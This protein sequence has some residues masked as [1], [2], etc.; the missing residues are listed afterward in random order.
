MIYQTA[1]YQ[2]N[3][4][5]ID[6]VKKAIKEFTLYVKKNEP[7]TILYLAWQKKDDIKTFM[8]FFIFEN[9][10]AQ[11]IHSKSRAVKKFESIYSPELVEKKVSFT[12]YELI[13]TNSTQ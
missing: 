12:D 7:G 9:E 4:Q 2:V 3:K 8:H 1:N 13:A 11:D 10:K 5:A 6:K